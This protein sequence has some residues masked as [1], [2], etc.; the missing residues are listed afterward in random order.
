[1]RCTSA[2]L[3]TVL[4]IPAT[5][6]AVLH[7]GSA[8]SATVLRQNTGEAGVRAAVFKRRTP[9]PQYDDVDA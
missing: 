5:L 3:I 1:M 8:S 4:F 6:S 2:L 9:H 7:F